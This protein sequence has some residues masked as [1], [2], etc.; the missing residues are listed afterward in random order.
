MLGGPT[1]LTV[2]TIQSYIGIPHFLDASTC[3]FIAW[4][5]D[6]ERI[7]GPC[8][9][10]VAWDCKRITRRVCCISRTLSINP[11][12]WIEK[13]HKTPAALVAVASVLIVNTV[14]IES[15]HIASTPSSYD[16]VPFL[17]VP[18]CPTSITLLVQP[19]N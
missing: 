1:L 4:S 3:R 6:G 15:G 18:Q 13:N 10:A 12:V 5:G 14:T 8:I 19:F 16:T 7:K 17:A 2:Y 9:A 11:H